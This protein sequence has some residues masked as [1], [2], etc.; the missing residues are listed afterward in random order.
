MIILFALFLTALFGMAALAVD[1]GHAFERRQFVQG[2]ANDAARS[3]AYEVYEN[4]VANDSTDAQVVKRM[5]DTLQRSGVSVYNLSGSTLTH[6]TPSAC[7]LNLSTNQALLEAVYLGSSGGWTVTLS[8]ATSG[9]FM[10]TTSGGLG[11]TTAAISATASAATVQSALALLPDV[12]G[13]ANV[14]VSGSP[15]GPYT[16]AFNPAAT[17]ND[18]TGTG[19]SGTT[20]SVVEP[21]TTSTGVAVGSGAIPMTA[22]GV[23]VT[24]LE[25]CVP[26]F[27]AGVLGFGKFVVDSDSSQS[28]VGWTK[29]DAF[30]NTPTQTSAARAPYYVFARVQCT[31]G[32]THASPTCGATP[33]RLF[34]LGSPDTLGGSNYANDHTKYGVTYQSSPNTSYPAPTCPSGLTC[35]GDLVTLHNHD[36]SD[37]NWDAWQFVQPWYGLANQ[38][39]PALPLGSASNRGCLAFPTPNLGLGE[40]SFNSP[41]TGNCAGSLT[42]GSVVN[43]PLVD[44]VCKNGSC[45]INADSTGTIGSCRPGGFC[46]RIIAFVQITVVR[47]YATNGFPL[48]QGYITGVIDDPYCTV[49][50][51]AP[52]P[53]TPTLQTHPTYWTNLAFASGTNLTSNTTAVSSTTLVAP[54]G[55]DGSGSTQ[56]KVSITNAITGTFDLAVTNDWTTDTATIP[57][58]APAT[59]PNSVQKLLAALPNVANGV[60]DGNLVTATGSGTTSDPYIITFKGTAAGDKP[61]SGLNFPTPI[62]TFPTIASNAQACPSTVP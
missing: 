40:W 44:Q 55:V 47:S 2:A 43:V 54:E 45:G 7:A 49:E 50:A 5:V 37:G 42:N 34:A 24:R 8:G 1:V 51:P 56:Y 16:V 12:N 9:T 48:D 38:A 15:G 25:M 4:L 28:L 3:G 35:S 11:G 36:N 46:V 52:P 14:T 13:T 19:G 18:L 30:T 22:A 57:Y 53:Q 61:I 33:Y 62:S 39:S 10:L 60:D 29:F 20:V 21:T 17:V 31:D 23:Q 41:G 26:H 6:L 59:G 27:F 32:S 58:N